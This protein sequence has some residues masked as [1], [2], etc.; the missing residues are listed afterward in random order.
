MFMK[1]E[2]ATKILALQKFLLNCSMDN[3]YNELKEDDAHLLD[4]LHIKFIEHRS[5]QVIKQHYSTKK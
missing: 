4:A 3:H 1:Y 2:F 5:Q